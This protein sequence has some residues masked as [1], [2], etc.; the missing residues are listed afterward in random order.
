MAE[1]MQQD[2]GY[3]Q[4]QN[5][6]IEETE[7]NETN[8]AQEE[9]DDEDEDERKVFVG[10]LSWET[11]KDD[12]KEYFEKYGEVE[13]TMLKTDQETK[14]S[15]GFGFVVFKKPETVDKV[16]SEK[17]HK[18]HK[19]TVETKKAN[20]RPINKK[21][22]VGKLD[23]AASEEEVTKYF[24]KFGPVKKMER[25]YDKQNEK[26]R[27][28]CFI[29]FKK[30]SGMKKCLEHMG[31]HKI[32]TM[33]VEIKKAT[34]PGGAAAGGPPMRGRGRGGFGGPGSRG[35]RGGGYQG[36]PGYGGNYPAY[37]G[38]PGYGYDQ[39]YGYGYDYGYNDGS[40]NYGG[41][42]QGYAPYG[43]YQGYGYDGWGYGQGGGQ[44]NYGKTQKRGAGGY[45][46][47]N[48]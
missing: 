18:L 7:E 45:H 10:G 34:P 8:N 29:E 22:F 40:W 6:T 9:D 14:K 42:Q 36:Y 20:P 33:E 47:Y 12:L 3:E 44:S 32:G 21:V 30:L 17:D 11:T 5:G 48:R 25:P 4:A 37:G 16:L 27:A 24:E 39:G 38:Y 41:Y 31:M 43:G 15:R 46:P 28:F 13:N 2:E 19:R 23:P 26:N 35:G 1:E